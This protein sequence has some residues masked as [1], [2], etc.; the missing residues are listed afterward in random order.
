M[1]NEINQNVK[2]T[3]LGLAL[4][5]KIVAAHGGKMWLTSQVHHGTTFYFTLPLAPKTNGA[6]NPAQRRL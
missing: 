4:A 1:D 2:G 5:K 6:M 3:G